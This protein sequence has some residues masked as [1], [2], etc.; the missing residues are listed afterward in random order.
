MGSLSPQ[1]YSCP[2][3]GP[4]GTS[5]EL[6]SVQGPHKLSKGEQVAYLVVVR[7]LGS[8]FHESHVGWQSC[9]GG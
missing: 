8:V 1:P 4:L 5:S 3:P 7:Q 9:L 2:V 6:T